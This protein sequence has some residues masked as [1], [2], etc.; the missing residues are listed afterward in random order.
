MRR[1]FG[2]ASL[3]SGLLLALLVAPLNLEAQSLRD[4][5]QI[6]ATSGYDGVYRADR[7]MPLH[8]TL[9]N[10]GDAVRGR[11][12]VRPE[13]SGRVVNSAFSVPVDLPSG[14]Q[15]R[16]HLY[17]LLEE[18][19]PSFVLELLD[20][21]G[22]RV[23][24]LVLRARSIQP[25]DRLHLLVAGEG[26]ASLPLNAL[27]SGGALAF[28][29]R[30]P[31]EDLPEHAALLEAVNTIFLL[32]I[33]SANLTPAQI[34]ALEQWT[35]HGGHLVVLGG[36]DGVE[37][38]ASLNGLLP[39]RISGTTSV[40][41]VAP[42]ADWT[43]VG[44]TG[45]DERAI[46]STGTLSEDARVLLRLTD[47]LPLLLRRDYG[48]GVIDLLA[49]DPTLE[50]LRSWNGL[51]DFWLRLATSRAPH[52]AWTQG[53][54]DPDEASTALAILP[55]QSLLPSP[56]SMMAFIAIYVLL[57]GPINYWVLTRINRRGLAWITIP[58][59]IVI[60]SGL[61]WSVGFNLR[62]AE[63]LVSRLRIIESHPQSETAREQQWIGVLSPRRANYTL[64]V[65]D[66]M[67]LRLLPELRAPGLLGGNLNLANT[68]LVQGQRAIARDVAIDGGIF[69][70]FAANGSTSRPAMSGTLTISTNED[71]TRTLQG[72][73]RNESQITLEDAVIL[74]QGVAYQL[75]T[76]FEPGELRTLAPNAITLAAQ[77]D[78]PA[79]A[80]LE[81][82]DAINPFDLLA[83]NLFT[84]AANYTTRN[85]V[86]GPRLLNRR[87]IDQINDSPALQ[88]N[89]RRDAFL[90]AFMRD[91]WGST[92]RGSR[93]FLIGWSSAPIADDF[94]LEG[95]P[96]SALDT[97]LYIIELETRVIPPLST[98]RVTLTPDD[99][100]W[101]GGE[102]EQ[103]QGGGPNDLILSETSLMTLRFTPIP[104]AQLRIVDELRVYLDRRSSGG[105]FVEV[106][107]WNW[108]RGEWEAFDSTL[109]DTYTISD[110]AR[111]LGPDNIVDMRLRIIN[112]LST[113]RIRSLTL[114]QSGRY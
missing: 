15:K 28:Q 65:P 39:L 113:A 94:V 6:E 1:F 45:L 4:L 72:A 109:P 7:W 48:A 29:A 63:V 92:A 74:A 11:L 80:P 24:D 55:G 88:E 90:S 40:E 83:R 70:N 43:G 8:V 33:A 21:E 13:S 96:W 20:E 16:E 98:Q 79:P 95:V 73:L 22:R 71:G 5:V 37:T 78:V 105:R 47:D 38:A 58:F 56:L 53:I 68:D 34:S 102:R 46:L 77:A 51:S 2:R 76:P 14:S 57:V 103:V 62:G 82:L 26:S 81:L 32:N 85:E 18:G 25:P 100:T 66:G 108:Q 3:L 84:A 36:P 86:L 87:Q 31:V 9:R 10:D 54:I 61:A 59:F 30:W 27:H 110:P 106:A 42:L 99:F 111:F 112:P 44:S 50:P 52:P 49:V 89:A 97:S 12:V 75:G 19:T 17:I 35:L 41:T 107:L 104:S 60:F 91:Q 69:A 114:T 23:Q 64:S 101:T 67:V 93:A